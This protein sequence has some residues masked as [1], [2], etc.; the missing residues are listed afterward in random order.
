[1]KYLYIIFLLFV[2]S[3][4]SLNKNSKYWNNVNQNVKSSN[5]YKE[6]IFSKILEKSDDI[7]SMS[8]DEYKIFLEDYTKKSNFPDINK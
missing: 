2:L 3:N 7:N 5:L 1:M 8:L 4:C 6:V